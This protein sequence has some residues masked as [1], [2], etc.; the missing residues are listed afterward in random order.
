MGRGIYVGWY[1]WYLAEMANTGIFK[2]FKSVRNIIVGPRSVNSWNKKGSSINWI[3]NSCSLPTAQ[4]IDQ[5][6]GMEDAVALTLLITT[7]KNTNRALKICT[8]NQNTCVNINFYPVGTYILNFLGGAGAAFRFL[9]RLHYKK[10][11]SPE[12]YGCQDQIELLS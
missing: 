3:H 12:H 4:Q 11:P 2:K 5:Q 1:L 6:L 10:R 8:V 9:L 7:P